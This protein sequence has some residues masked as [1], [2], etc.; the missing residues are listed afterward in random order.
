MIASADVAY[1]VIEALARAKGPMTVKELLEEAPFP[2]A[3]VAGVLAVLTAI[4]A[5]EK[6]ADRADYTLKRQLSAYQITK[7]AEL[8]VDLGTLGRL[9]SISD[10]QKQAAMSLATQGEKLKELDDQLRAK[11]QAERAKP[12][13]A[14]PR[15][16]IVETLER[17]AMASQASL[18]ECQK[19]GAGEEVVLALQE[20]RDQALKA[21]GEYQEELGKSAHVGF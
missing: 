17:L 14:L 10:K 3:S 9:L 15:D 2:R 19:S 1:V 6:G 12:A 5:A 20:A 8:G 13:D 7:L 21:L 4:G 16:T 18:E 11:R